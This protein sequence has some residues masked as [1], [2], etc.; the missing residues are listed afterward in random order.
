MGFVQPQPGVPS[1]FLAAVTACTFDATVNA[2]RDARG[3]QLF[4]VLGM[5]AAGGS[6]VEW[7]VDGAA[8]SC[9]R[10]LLSQQTFEILT[11]GTLQT[12]GAI[13]FRGVR[14]RV[15]A[16]GLSGSGGGMLCSAVPA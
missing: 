9:P 1:P 10:A 16:A 5:G 3:T 4:P 15:I 12:D 7:G 2:L 11:L 8:S 13:L 6:S 14:Y